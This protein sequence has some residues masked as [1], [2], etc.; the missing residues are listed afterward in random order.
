MDDDAE[1]LR[2]LLRQRERPGSDESENRDADHAPVAHGR[3]SRTP[4]ALP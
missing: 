3:L 4:V 2:R 1:L